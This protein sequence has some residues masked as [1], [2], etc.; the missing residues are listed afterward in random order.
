[1]KSL[2]LGGTAKSQMQFAA[3]F[4][5]DA[6]G[7]VLLS[8][9]HVMVGGLVVRACLAPARVLANVHGRLAVHAQTDDPWAFSAPILGPDVGE[10]GV[11]FR[12]FFWGLALSTAR[13]R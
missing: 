3:I 10:D 9:A 4:V 1:M 2:V 12:D 11:G 7:C 6:E 13:K 5:D 8:T